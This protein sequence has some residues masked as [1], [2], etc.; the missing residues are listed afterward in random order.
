MGKSIT[1]AGLV[2]AAIVDEAWQQVAVSF[3]RF[4]LRAGIA[5]L[6]EM[7]EKDAAGLCGVRYV[8]GF[9]CRPGRSWSRAL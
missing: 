8:K 3:E 5:T 2:P 9:G 6:A 4:C 7:M 1:P